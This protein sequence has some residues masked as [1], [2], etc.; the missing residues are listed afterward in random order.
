MSDKT[1]NTSLIKFATSKTPTASFRDLGGQH[2][3]DIDSSW[4]DVIRTTPESFA[5]RSPGSFIEEKKYTIA[6]ITGQPMKR[7]GLPGPGN[8]WT[9]C[10]I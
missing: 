9:T 4:K 3:T 8:Y 10:T 2:F 7:W 1:P 5:D 6:G